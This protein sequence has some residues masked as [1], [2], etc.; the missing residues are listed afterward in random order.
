LS[1]VKAIPI[2]SKTALLL[3]YRARPRDSWRSC[4]SLHR[5]RCGGSG[6]VLSDSL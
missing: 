5:R 4:D 3:S 6:L 1:E 2:V